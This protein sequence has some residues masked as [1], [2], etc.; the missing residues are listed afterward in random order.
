[1]HS[2]QSDEK[3]IR[4]TSFGQSNDQGIQNMETI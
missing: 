2:T 3:N 1:L 4:A